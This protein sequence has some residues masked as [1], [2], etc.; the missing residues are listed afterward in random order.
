MYSMS[1]ETREQLEESSLLPCR[2]WGS[3]SDFSLVSST[4]QL[5]HLIV[6]LET[7]HLIYP[8]NAYISYPIY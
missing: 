3:N 2:T 5:Y 4:D 6:H 8:H 1:V 7:E